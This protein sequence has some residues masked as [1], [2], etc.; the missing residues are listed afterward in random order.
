MT[1]RPVTR[2]ISPWGEIH[3]GVKLPLSMRK[4]LQVVTCCTSGEIS[5]RVIL[6][7]SY[8]REKFHPGANSV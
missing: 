8:R 7:P 1:K 4:L 3:P 2:E 5:P 6:S